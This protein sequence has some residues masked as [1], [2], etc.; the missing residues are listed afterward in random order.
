MAVSSTLDPEKYVCGLESTGQAINILSESDLLRSMPPAMRAKLIDFVQRQQD[1]TTGF[2]YDAPWTRNVNRLA[3]RALTYAVGTLRDLNAQPLH[4]L[5][6]AAAIEASYPELESPEKLRTWLGRLPWKK[7][8]WGSGDQINARLSVFSNLPSE[9]REPLLQNLF[10]YLVTI[11]SPQTGLWG[12]DPAMINFNYVS[13]G[14]KIAMVYDH[15]HRAVPQ[16]DALY[17]STL[18]CLRTQTP[19]RYTFVRNPLSLIDY[20]MPILAQPATAAERLEIIDITIRN[21]AQFLKSDGGFSRY[22]GAGYKGD[23]PAVW[24]AGLAEGDLNSGT[25]AINVVRRM[26]YKLAGISETPLPGARSFYGNVRVI[27]G[28]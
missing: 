15:F 7:D 18:E 2:F 5:P 23:V 19:D 25:Q 17:R 11:Q 22:P 1:A 21:N 26:C 24:S 3:G 27:A 9:Q 4:P 10:S 28:Q 8:P 14:F 13:G 12:T 20:I 6:G 16:P